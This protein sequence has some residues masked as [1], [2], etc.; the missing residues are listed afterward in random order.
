MLVSVW[1]KRWREINLMMATLYID[2]SGTDPKQHV[3][4][5]TVLIIPASQ[6]IRLER[7]WNTLREKEHFRCFHTSECMAK[8]AK[9]E[10]ANWDDDKIERVFRRVRQISKKYG[11]RAVSIAVNKKDYDE[12]VPPEFR[13]YIGKYHYTW[14]V[15]Q[16][17]SFIE[18]HFPPKPAREFIFQWLERKDK[19]R[20]EIEDVM[21]Q[22]QWLACKEGL[23]RDYADPQFRKSDD[24]PGLQC[25]D[26]IG[27]ICYQY[28]L[29][30][31]RKTPLKKYI[32]ESWHHFGAHLSEEGWLMAFTILR[33][34]LQKLIE[35]ALANEK[36]M[37]I[38]KEWE[39]HKKERK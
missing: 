19:A 8:N 25:V 30:L 6:I 27:W 32:D 29:L 17:L 23:P 16:L 15:R 13:N 28:S 34:K 12:L 2:D 22:A 11:A 7:E 37:A 31:F 1:G 24:I 36:A 3:A 4:I 35:N 9:S 33:D 14:A 38:F 10:F 26:A 21:D 20:K 5:A 18:P 39:E